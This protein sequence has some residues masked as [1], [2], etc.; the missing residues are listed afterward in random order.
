MAQCKVVISLVCWLWRLYILAVYHMNFLK[1]LSST[2][3]RYAR[4]QSK[5][6]TLLDSRW[7][8]FLTIVSKVFFKYLAMNQVNW[9]NVEKPQVMDVE[10]SC[11]RLP[12][13]MYC[14]ATVCYGSDTS[15]IYNNNG[16]LLRGVRSK[17]LALQQ[18]TIPTPF[19]HVDL[20]VMI[21]K[22]VCVITCTLLCTCI[23]I[24]TKF[25]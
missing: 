8:H 13:I 2:S 6:F 12:L 14:K 10:M 4:V 3:Q 16:Y 25:L 7:C 23:Y 11:D 24:D 9:V 15:S 5:L 19:Q 22:Q 17:I 20:F 18:E 21:H 1:W